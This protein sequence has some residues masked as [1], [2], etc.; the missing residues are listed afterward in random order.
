MRE[1]AD[2]YLDTEHSSARQDLWVYDPDLKVSTDER[3]SFSS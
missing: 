3:P 1:V 2:A